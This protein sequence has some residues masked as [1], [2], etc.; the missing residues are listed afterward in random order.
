MAADRRPTEERKEQIADAAL[1][2]ISTRGVHRLTA[3]ELAREVGIAD[4]TI[5]RHFKDKKAIVRAAIE[6][7]EAL[8]FAGEAPAHADPLERLEAFFVRR[9]TLVQKAPAVFLAALNDRLL[10]AAED[11]GHL[12]LSLVERSQ[13]FVRD[14][15][16]EAQARG[17]VAKDLPVDV[18]TTVVIGTLQAS[19]FLRHKS[20]RARATPEQAWQVVERLLRGSAG[21]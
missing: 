1:R 3:M 9:L 12:V 15:L 2:I 17:Q 6:R 13:V 16:V 21:R 5:F 18:L 10:E 11:D 14:C 8:L 20:K 4:G 7:M 19:A